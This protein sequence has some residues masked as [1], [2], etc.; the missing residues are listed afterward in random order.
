ME[1]VKKKIIFHL[2]WTNTKLFFWNTA[3]YIDANFFLQDL[4]PVILS[5]YPAGTSMKAL[6][7]YGQLMRTGKISD[8][9]NSLECIITGLHT[10]IFKT[11]TT[12]LWESW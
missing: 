6:V 12:S 11:I 2:A 3:H 8:Q 1:Y 7:H 10:T 5:H 9:Q 4:L